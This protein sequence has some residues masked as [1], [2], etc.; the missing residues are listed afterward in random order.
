MESRLRMLLVLAGLPE[1]TVNYAV[2]DA[3]GRVRRRLDLCY[4]AAKVIVEY[5]GRQHAENEDQWAGDIDRR[6]ELDGDQWRLIV[7]ISRGIYREP[8]RTLQR[9]RS[10]LTERGVRVPARFA[11]E[12]QRYFPGY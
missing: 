8:L 3:Q 7:V 12:W 1:P 6:E 4:L 10:A 9:V 11:T 2:R 5:D